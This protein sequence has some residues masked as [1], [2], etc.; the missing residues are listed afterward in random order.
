[1]SPPKR[2]RVAEQRR[3]TRCYRMCGIL[4]MIM[5]DS[6]ECHGAS[7]HGLLFVS[8]FPSSSPPSFSFFFLTV[9]QM[10]T[11]IYS[12]RPRLFLPLLLSFCFFVFSEEVWTESFGKQNI[13]RQR[14]DRGRR[15]KKKRKAANGVIHTA[16]GAAPQIGSD[17][18]SLLVYL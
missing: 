7:A 4:H 3:C 14:E 16:T 12:D 9:F 17:V 1:M 18:S 2:S 13:A 6:R 15:A 8:H 5:L 11:V 10:A